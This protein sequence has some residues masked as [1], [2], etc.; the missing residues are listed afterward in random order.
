MQLIEALSYLE[1][2]YLLRLM[3]SVH[4]YCWDF[5]A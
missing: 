3:T 2:D 5:A 4:K 1:D